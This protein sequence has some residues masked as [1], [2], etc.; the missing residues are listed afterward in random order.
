MLGLYKPDG[1]VALVGA[2][3]VVVLTKPPQPLTPFHAVRSP[4]YA[5]YDAENTW[6]PSIIYHV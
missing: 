1:P 2:G 5:V 4:R 6:N 3:A